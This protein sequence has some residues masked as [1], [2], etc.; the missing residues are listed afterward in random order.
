V[1]GTTLIEAVTSNLRNSDFFTVSP[2]A[3]PSGLTDDSMRSSNLVFAEYSS[4]HKPV[5]IR[6]Y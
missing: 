3:I 2:M 1:E 6:L 4:W 5:G